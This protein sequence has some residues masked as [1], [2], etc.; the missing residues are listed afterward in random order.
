M[1]YIKLNKQN[2]FYNL[3]VCAKQAGD[4]NKLAIVLKDNAYGHGLLQIATLA[5]EFGIK[6]A[7]VQTYKEA[8]TIEHL[9][10]AILILADTKIDT[11]SHSFHIAINDLQ[12]L[13]ELCENTNIHIKIDTGMHRNGISPE[14]LEVAIYRALELKLNICGIFTHHKS[15]DELTSDFFYQNTIFQGLK[16]EVKNICEKLNMPKIA[17]HSCNSA[18]LFRTKNFTEDFARIGIAS[19]GYLDGVD[20]LNFPSLR[21]V[22]SLYGNKLSSRTLK[23]AQRAGY[24]GTYSASEDMTVSTYDIGYGDGFRRLGGTEFKTSCGKRILGRVSMDSIIVEGNDEEI[25]IFDNVSEL[26]K[27]HETITY[28]MLTSLNQNLKRVID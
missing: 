12:S 28:E 23:K 5:N 10:D 24:G 3:E 8:I 20:A 17:F 16:E 21:P 2:L 22:L 6:K 9:F 18:A 19:Y 15:A 4:K 26:S 14:M 27:I 7:V 13:E 1:S 11:L 25:C